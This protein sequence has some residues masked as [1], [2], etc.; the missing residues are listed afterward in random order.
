MINVE[1]SHS[2]ET[3]VWMDVGK[4]IKNIN[5]YFEAKI[6]CSE[7]KY[8]IYLMHTHPKE[9]I[10]N[11]YLKSNLFNSDYVVD[12][13]NDVT[14]PPSISD[15]SIINRFSSILAESI[16]AN[17]NFSLIGVVVDPTGLYF[18][19]VLLDDEIM[20][21]FPSLEIIDFSSMDNEEY[22]IQFSNLVKEIEGAGSNWSTLFNSKLGDVKTA[23]NE[24]RK[25][26]AKYRFK[27]DFV[28]YK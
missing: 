11:N 2:S 1:V 16:V 21:E 23:Y 10:K 4:T 24:L 5:K 20:N 15:L 7:I 14:I 28:K 27:I 9:S 25:S 3:I 22:E 17:I 12:W 18:Y 6:N 13:N 19:R 8:T 26:Y